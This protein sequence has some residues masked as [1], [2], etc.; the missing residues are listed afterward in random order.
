MLIINESIR[1]I[2]AEVC[3]LRTKIIKIRWRRGVRHAVPLQAML[4][5]RRLSGTR[6]DIDGDFSAILV[7][8][9]GGMRAVGKLQAQ[10]VRPRRERQ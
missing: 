9:E 5:C 1:L 4:N 2:E 8:F 10:D 7:A 6:R 3:E